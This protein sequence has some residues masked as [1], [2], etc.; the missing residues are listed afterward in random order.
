MM[1]AWRRERLESQV[2]LSEL[3]ITG[4]RQRGPV[5]SVLLP[6]RTNRWTACGRRARR[7]PGWIPVD[8]RWRLLA[9]Y[10]S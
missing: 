6:V 9:T 1:R 3:F 8:G 10:L 5:A 7:G 4:P 2:E